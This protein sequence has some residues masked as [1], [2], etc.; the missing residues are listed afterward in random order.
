MFWKAINWIGDNWKTIATLGLPILLSFIISL[1][2]GNKSLEKKV[3]LKEKE[4]DIERDSN[5]IEQAALQHAI[6]QKAQAVEQANAVHDALINQVKDDMQKRFEEIQTAEQ[7]TEEIK[8]KL[9][10]PEVPA[11]KLVKPE[12]IKPPKYP[13]PFSTNVNRKCPCGSGYKYKYCHMKFWSEK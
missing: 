2:R 5:A 10:E 3:E 11:W 13:N 8:E 12:D 7:A 4:N 1:L 6:D 9:A